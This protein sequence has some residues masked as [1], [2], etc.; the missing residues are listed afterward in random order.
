M[1]ARASALNFDMDLA[2]RARLITNSR[3]IGFD[4]N[5]V[6]VGVFPKRTSLYG[7]WNDVA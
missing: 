2:L 6:L 1:P 5:S 3:P 7:L 4:M